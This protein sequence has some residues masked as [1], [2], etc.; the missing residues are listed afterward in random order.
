MV[1]SEP[2]VCVSTRTEAACL[3][4]AHSGRPLSIV[5]DLVSR[6]EL[7]DVVRV[8]LVSAGLAV[9]VVEGYCRASG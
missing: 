5:S 2:P 3:R 7:G 6:D 4:G 9:L 8:V 1:P